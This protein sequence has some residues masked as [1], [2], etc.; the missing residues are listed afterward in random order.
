M[1][2]RARAVTATDV[3]QLLRVRFAPPAWA[4]FEEVANATGYGAKRTADAIAMSLWPS[5]GLEVHGVEIKVSRSDWVHERDN[6]AKDEAIAQYCDRWWLAVGDA[7]IVRAC[8]LPPM[9][10]LLAVRGGRLVAVTEAPKLTPKP[11]DAAFVAAMLRR[12]HEAMAHMV[13]KSELTARIAERLQQRVDALEAAIAAFQEASGVALH[14]W[15]AGNIGRAVATV[16]RATGGVDM[17]R[18]RLGQLVTF[19][20]S[21]AS[22]MRAELE[23]L[24]K[25][26]P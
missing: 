8:E 25:A 17:Q 5:R 13:P 3:R 6:P 26:H 7:E 11:L 21:V 15:N 19:A 22:T 1:S 9:W 23:A 4:M 20:E 12:A 2:K 16:L 10:G 14:P 24:D 18:Q